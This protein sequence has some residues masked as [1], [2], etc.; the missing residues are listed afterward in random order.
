MEN[1]D[2]EVCV[3]C[4]IEIDKNN[5]WQFEERYP[6]SDKSCCDICVRENSDISP[7]DYE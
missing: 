4:G 1:K 7:N 2:K 6:Y 3:F 5:T